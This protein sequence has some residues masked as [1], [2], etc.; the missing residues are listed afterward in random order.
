VSLILPPW[1]NNCKRRLQRPL[2]AL[3]HWDRAAPLSGRRSDD[4]HHP[5]AIGQPCRPTKPARAKN[6]IKEAKAA[7]SRDASTEIKFSTV[8]VK[9]LLA[10]KWLAL[11]CPLLPI[12]LLF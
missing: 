10:K 12:T 7:A 9:R 4:D 8:T 1:L 3:H 6:K 11:R 2:P 5:V